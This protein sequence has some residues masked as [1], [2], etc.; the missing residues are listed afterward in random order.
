MTSKTRLILTST[1]PLEHWIDEDIDCNF[2]TV[3]TASDKVQFTLWVHAPS[4]NN[5]GAL[6]RQILPFLKQSHIWIERHS[7]PMN[8]VQTTTISWYS[9]CN[10]PDT[11][12]FMTAQ[13]TLNTKIQEYLATNKAKLVSYANDAEALPN[14]NGEYLLPVTLNFFKPDWKTVVNGQ[15]QHWKT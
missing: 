5:V 14:W 1:R 10:H 11:I 2:H 12:D 8:D 15:T 9:T 7:T 4:I 3:I 13:R 6:K